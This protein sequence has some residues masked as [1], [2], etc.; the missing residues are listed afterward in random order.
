MHADKLGGALHSANPCM[1]VVNL[2][3][4]TT[5]SHLSC[6]SLLHEHEAD[7]DNLP[8]LF[9]CMTMPFLLWQQFTAGMFDRQDK[10]IV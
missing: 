9:K 6:M 3:T 5:G 10:K 4:P 2:D 7:P 1:L 8:G